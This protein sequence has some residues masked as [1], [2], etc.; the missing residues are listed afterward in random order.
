MNLTVRRALA[1][2]TAPVVLL[3]LA[4]CGGDGTSAAKASS[5]SSASPT[6]SATGSSSEESSPSGSTGGSGEP[7]TGDAFA[8]VLKDALD[9]ATTAHVA[10]QLGGSTGSAQGD[11]DYT[12]NP[13]ELAMTMKVAELGGD[14]EVR[15]VA[16]TMFMKAATFGDKWVSVPL[17]DPNSPLGSLG[18]LF[19]VTKTLQNFAN[20]V[21]S[22]THSS[23]D[24]DGESLDHYA[25]TV[26]TQKLLQSMP[27]L[28]S[29]AS[30]LPE[31]MAQEWWFDGDGLIRKFSTDFGSTST[32]MTFSDWGEDV[33]IE[34]PPSDEVTSMP[35]AGS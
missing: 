35:G 25:A 11:A 6:G 34:A 23:E 19:D 30:S 26:D 15:M 7:V 10:M 4:G 31:T 1:T 28:S 17:D 2:A 5:T 22:A 16:G 33:S 18:G 20:A 12:K 21:T 29:A 32:V 8:A 9:K 24:V 13:P 27:E 3:A 14:V